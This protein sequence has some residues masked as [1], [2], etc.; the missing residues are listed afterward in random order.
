LLSER[1]RICKRFMQGKRFFAAF[2]IS[3]DR[4]FRDKSTCTK[5]HRL[6]AGAGRGISP[7]NLLSASARNLT[8]VSFLS[9]SGILP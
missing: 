6:L 8:D 4:R 2:A 5:L 3:P 7:I 9:S 1:S